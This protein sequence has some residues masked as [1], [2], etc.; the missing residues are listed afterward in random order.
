MR[1]RVACH[2]PLETCSAYSYTDRSTCTSGKLEELLSGGLDAKQQPLA[3]RGITQLL[4]DALLLERPS[5]E[6]SDW[7]YSK[8]FDQDFYEVFYAG[9]VKVVVS[10]KVE[11]ALVGHN[12]LL[13]ST[14]C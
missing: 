13:L 10:N 14:W 6:L 2:H 7:I 12:H 8:G 5:V 1:L 3:L 9:L 11:G 4:R